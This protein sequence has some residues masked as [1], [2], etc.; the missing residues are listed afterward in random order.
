[1]VAQLS[2]ET[3]GTPEFKEGRWSRRL[4]GQS[5]FLWTWSARESRGHLCLPLHWPFTNIWCFLPLRTEATKH[6]TQPCLWICHPERSRVFKC[7]VF[8]ILIYPPINHAAVRLAPPNLPFLRCSRHG[9]LWGLQEGHGPGKSDALNY[10]S[11][12]LSLTV[13]ISRGFPTK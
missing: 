1:M 5:C 8:D 6:R 10:S 9:F 3:Q 7:A 4:A 13:L 12:C 2:K 11:P